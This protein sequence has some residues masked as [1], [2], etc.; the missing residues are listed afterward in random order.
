M[1]PAPLALVAA[2]AAT[3]AACSPSR[4]WVKPGATDE[5]LRLAQEECASRGSSFD[6]AFE[7]RDSG[8][9][10]VVESAPDNRERRAGSA[11]GD[12]YRACMESQ[13]W[14]RER[15]NPSQPK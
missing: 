5:D 6:F 8:R 3:I 4:Q 13:G 9:P 11:R 7:D 12:V 15:A 10:G 14:R 1:K 2:L